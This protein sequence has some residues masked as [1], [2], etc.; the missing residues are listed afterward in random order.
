MLLL[1]SSLLLCVSAHHQT[2]EHAEIFGSTSLGYYYVDLQVGTPA[3]KQTVIVDTGSTVTAFPCTGCRNCGHHLDSYFDYTLS[4]TSRLVTC[5]ENIDCSTCTNNQC[6]YHQGYTEGSSIAGYYIE[7]FVQFG[8]DVSANRVKFIFG[9]HDSET[10]LFR[11]QLADGIMGLAPGTQRRKTLIDVIY[12]S[13][14]VNVDVFSLCLGRIGGFMTIGGFNS[15]MHLSPLQTIPM[16]ENSFYNVKLNGITVNDQT[17]ATPDYMANSGTIL[18]SGTTF[19]YLNTVLY[20]KL[21]NLFMSFCQGSGKC[22]SGIAVVRGETHPCY[23]FEVGKIEDF[24][25]SFPVIYMNFA[26]ESVGW[27][28]ESYLFAWPDQPTHFCLG[29]YSNGGGS[30][31]LGGLFMRNHD[32]IFNRTSQTIS[33]AHSSCDPSQLLSPHRSLQSFTSLSKSH[34][35]WYTVCGAVIGCTLA[36]LGSVTLVRRK[37]RH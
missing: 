13:H 8:D 20:D 32:I 2:Y 21:W 25:A 33:F 17:F 22:G 28:A 18:D 6:H 23:K 4:N 24:Y 30:S 26:G 37:C 1:L 11:T 35:E 19:V 16:N 3:V 12:Q 31:V 27:K 7:D 34:T 36:V 29:V 15:S 9:C 14:N 5:S 10:N